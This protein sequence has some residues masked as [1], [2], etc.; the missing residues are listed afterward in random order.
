MTDKCII[1][2]EELRTN[3]GVLTPCGHCFHRECF[4]ALKK[5]KEKNSDPS[6]D[7]GGKLPRCPICK[8]KSKKFIPIYLNFEDR[9]AVKCSNRK[10]KK[11]SENRNGN[12][13][14]TKNGNG[15]DNDS[16]NENDNED[17][18]CSSSYAEA[19][20]ALASLTSE[21]MRLRKSLQEIKSVSKGQN[22]L[23]VEVLP[24]YDDIKSKLAIT[25]KEKERIE[26]ELKEVEEENSEL[27]TG[28]NDIEMKMQMVKIEKDELE[29]R[30][31]ETKRKNNALTTKWNELDQKLIKAKK[32][33]KVLES[34]QANELQG[35]KLEI[36]KSNMEKQDLLNILKKSQM[37][38]RELKRTI[39]KL[40][41]KQTKF[42]LRKKN[43]SVRLT[44]SL[45]HLN[46]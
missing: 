17:W 30:L 36:S 20:Q 6:T 29:E 28:W 25:T 10:R 42:E 3:I 41:R 40:R 31:R 15:N 26:K 33:R 46:V 37:K 13:N 19:T 23:L 1:C 24:R 22:E 12:T 35:V 8:H 7:D 21:N 44:E 16:D 32:K 14:E 4:H 9:P 39:K 11:S 27:L 38:S 18:V 2:L 43:S 5:N 45:Y 34:K